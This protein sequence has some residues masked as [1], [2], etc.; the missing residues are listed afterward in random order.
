ML[1]CE[2][3]IVIAGLQLF[4]VPYFSSTKLKMS[5]ASNHEP[6]LP[7]SPEKFKRLLKKGAPEFLPA[8]LFYGRTNLPDL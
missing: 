3:S 4:F 1:A 5:F 7:A 2:E 8:P 6:S